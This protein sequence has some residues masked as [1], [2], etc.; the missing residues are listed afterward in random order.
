MSRT[1]RP[2]TK[3][4]EWGTLNDR[5]RA[6]TQLLFLRKLGL[7]QALAACGPG[8]GKVQAHPLGLRRPLEKG[9]EVSRGARGLELGP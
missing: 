8:A 5:H 1:Y 4:Q 3:D 2:R 7:A 6:T 9:I